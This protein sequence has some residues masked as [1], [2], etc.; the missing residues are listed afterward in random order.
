MHQH[1][2][3]AALVDQRARIDHTLGLARGVE[4]VEHF[5]LERLVLGLAQAAGEFRGRWQRPAA[6]LGGIEPV[7]E[8]D[9]GVFAQDF[10]RRGAVGTLLELRGGDVARQR[11]QLVLVAQQRQAHALLCPGGVAVQG[12]ALLLA[13][14][15]VQGPQDHAHRH[16]EQYD[17]NQ[18]DEHEPAG[19]D[20][21]APAQP[22]Q[23]A[24]CGH[25]GAVVGAQR[26]DRP[27]SGRRRRGVRGIASGRLG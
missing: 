24:R 2:A 25:G 13:L 23:P 12:V 21:V 4:G 15:L 19:G 3:V 27:Q 9:L 16:R 10:L 5:G 7:D 11:G 6:A 20:Q 18:R 1:E 8:D 17:G 26:L 14:G 22:P